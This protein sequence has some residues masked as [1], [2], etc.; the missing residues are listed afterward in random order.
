M[1]SGNTHVQQQHHLNVQPL[2]AHVDRFSAQALSKLQ[3]SSQLSSSQ[4][5]EKTD[6]EK[7]KNKSYISS[8]YVNVQED[9]SHKSQCLEINQIKKLQE[10]QSPTYKINIPVSSVNLDVI[11]PQSTTLP[12][13]IFSNQNH[14]LTKSS[15]VN[16]HGKKSELQTDL[17]HQ[18][19]FQP[20]KTEHQDYNSSNSTKNLN[21]F[22]QHDQLQINNQTHVSL[23]Q[24][25]QQSEL[26]LQQL[27]EMQT[28]NKLQT[29]TQVNQQTPTSQER[30]KLEDCLIHSQ[31]QQAK[32][33]VS[34]QKKIH[35]SDQM[36]LGVQ[37]SVKLEYTSQKADKIEI[38]S[39]LPKHNKQQ[40][41]STLAIILPKH[42]PLPSQKLNIGEDTK[43]GN[44]QKQ[45][46]LNLVN[47]EQY[48][49][50]ENTLSTIYQ[51]SQSSQHSKMTS[52]PQLNQLQESH[53]TFKND[54]NDQIIDLNHLQQQQ[55][56]NKT[57]LMQQQTQHLSEQSLHK[58]SQQQFCL[59]QSKTPQNQKINTQQTINQAQVKMLQHHHFN[60]EISKA[61]V[62]VHDLLNSSNSA[63][64]SQFAQLLQN[65]NLLHSLSQEQMSVMLSGTNTGNSTSQQIPGVIGFNSGSTNKIKPKILQSKSQPLQQ[66]ISRPQSVMP[67]SLNL[68][69]HTQ[70]SA[71]LQR[72]LSN[73]AVAAAAVNSN[74]LVPNVST[75][76]DFNNDPSV[77][78]QL[79]ALYNRFNL[80]NNPL[81]HQNAAAIY[82]R[83]LTPNISSLQKNCK[84]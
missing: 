42:A 65:P 61:P 82:A 55:D 26:Q 52:I 8:N 63:T 57:I 70:S 22:Q 6:D 67:T 15:I 84:Y 78:A 24:I 27:T 53:Q 58:D 34:E 81:L 14:I 9:V 17:C 56:K 31:L 72:P 66:Q 37:H 64:T 33:L 28:Q 54:L 46:N 25:E 43:K 19:L 5:L 11:L 21:Q 68:E 30:L 40:P 60:D 32:L 7:E 4:I 39:N 73:L 1:I 77:N 35:L 51:T 41:T 36:Q 16:K 59:Q 49:I 2:S 74:I 12:N 13:L 83:T 23:S 76:S 79:L 75:S 80:M 50:Q 10:P 18:N 29:Y 69:S 47:S 20:F 44:F 45:Q 48:K 38:E 71:Q 3:L 62:S